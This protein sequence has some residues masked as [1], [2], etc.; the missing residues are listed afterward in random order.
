MKK[1]LVVAAILA[2][3]AMPSMA[4]AQASALKI[5]YIDMQRAIMESEKGKEANQTI[6]QFAE[7][8]KKNI[9]QKQE[10]LQKLKDSLDK[11]G[12][13]I[14]PDARAEK[15][16][17]YQSKLKDY[18]RIVNDADG[19]M[20]QKQMEIG[21]KLFKEVLEVVK[22]IGEKE[23]YTLVVEKGQGGVVFASS[24]IDI[25]G[26]VIAAYNESVKKKASAPKK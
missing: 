14:T 15:E 11:Q 24:S 9:G 19:E 17:Q 6:M 23:K 12:V 26:K 1:L 16:K 7:G 10:E 2:F 13:V 22:D 20:Q 8:L 21:Q 5:A 3:I 25:T 18:Q 4:K